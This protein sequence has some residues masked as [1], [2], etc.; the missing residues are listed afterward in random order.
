MNNTVGVVWFRGRFGLLRSSWVA[1]DSYHRVPPSPGTSAPASPSA[2]TARPASGCGPRRGGSSSSSGL[3][4][5]RSCPAPGCGPGA[6]RSSPA[7]RGSGGRRGS[8]RRWRPRRKTRAGPRWRRWPRRTRR[9]RARPSPLPPPRT[10]G[11]R[12][13]T[14]S[15]C[16]TDLPVKFG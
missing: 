13:R 1:W 7:L 6:Q 16:A 8:R 10:P 4:C 15:L 2:A 14:R 9:G 5:S 12:R 3:S 11:S